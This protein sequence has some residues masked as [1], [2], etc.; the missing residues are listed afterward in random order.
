[1]DENDNSVIILE[2][3]MRKLRRLA[4]EKNVP[5]YDVIH[6]ALGNFLSFHDTGFNLYDILG[7]IESGMT[8][9]GH[10]IT[11]VDLGNY[12]VSIKSPVRYIH[13][14]ELKY[15]IVI[16]QND[17]IS[18]GKMSVSLR[19]QDIYTLQRFSEFISLWMG[20][21]TKYIDSGGK[22]TYKTDTGRFERNVYLPAYAGQVSGQ[23]IGAAI[24]DY[25]HVFDEL[26]KIYFHHSK[27]RLREIEKLYRGYKLNGKL[28]I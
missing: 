21:E 10:F 5:V 22:I 16:T 19:S 26:L 3:M 13:R 17:S 20:L 14:P 6:E 18:I 1:M 15:Q 23:A 12:A 27:G 7:S 2:E 9:P 8:V 4:L 28:K 24:S 11:N 25:V